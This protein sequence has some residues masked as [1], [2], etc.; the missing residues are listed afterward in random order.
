M[1]LLFDDSALLKSLLASFIIAHPRQSC[2]LARVSQS[3]A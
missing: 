3:A 1:F 2:S